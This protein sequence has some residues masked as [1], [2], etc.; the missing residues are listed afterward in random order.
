MLVFCMATCRA[1][2][3]AD[4]LSGTPDH[5]VVVD[6]K[7]WAWYLNFTHEQKVAVRAID[8]RC[9]ERQAVLDRSAD[10]VDTGA[11]RAERRKAVAAWTDEVE[12]ALDPARFTRWL[13][14][15]NGAR[16]VKPTPMGAQGW[17]VGLF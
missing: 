13:N 17:R 15:R 5:W 9:A 4:S 3:P 10:Y 6:L 11:Q 2:V 8:A 1:Q 12:A 14:L 16:P 7:E